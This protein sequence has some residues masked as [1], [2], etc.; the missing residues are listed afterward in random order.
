MCVEWFCSKIYTE[1]GSAPVPDG[2]MVSG[3]SMGNL[4]G[5]LAARQANVNNVNAWKDGY[6]N[7]ERNKD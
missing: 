6:V 5:L 3:G 2:V 7:G 1:S 4:T